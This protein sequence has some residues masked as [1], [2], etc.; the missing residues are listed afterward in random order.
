MIFICYFFVGF[1]LCDAH[2]MEALNTP[3]TKVTALSYNYSDMMANGQHVGAS[4]QT[5]NNREF[6]WTVFKRCE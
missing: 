5:E 3:A 2:V 6:Q 1:V 4:F